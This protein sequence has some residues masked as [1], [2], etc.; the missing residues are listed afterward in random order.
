MKRGREEYDEVFEESPSKKRVYPTM[1]IPVLRKKAP[2]L[3]RLQR[4][5]DFAIHVKFD[6]A[7]NFQ[8]KL[9]YLKTMLEK[10]NLKDVFKVFQPFFIQILKEDIKTYCNAM[11]FGPMKVAQRISDANVTYRAE[12]YRVG[13]KPCVTSHYIPKIC[14][15]CKCTFLTYEYK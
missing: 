1:L 3:E 5:Y 10:N 2:Q 13:G 9:F 8:Q 4:E 11:H 12:I 14:P 6:P 7:P 15:Y